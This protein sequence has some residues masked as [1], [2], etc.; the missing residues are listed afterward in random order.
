MERRRHAAATLP[1][2]RRRQENRELEV[3]KKIAGKKNHKHKSAPPLPL[4]ITRR[5]AAGEARRL[6]H[7]S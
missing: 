2:P 6:V 4:R 3:E 5:A 7:A 1:P